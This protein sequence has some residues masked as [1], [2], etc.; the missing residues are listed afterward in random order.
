MKNVTDRYI[1]VERKL[2]HI[3]ISSIHNPERNNGRTYHVHSVSFLVI[4][5]IEA[6]ATAIFLLQAATRNCESSDYMNT[7]TGSK[8]SVDGQF[9]SSDYSFVVL[10]GTCW[11]ME[12]LVIYSGTRNTLQKNIT[13]VSFERAPWEAAYCSQQMRKSIVRSL[14]MWDMLPNH[15]GPSKLRCHGNYEQYLW[16]GKKILEKL[17]WWSKLWGLL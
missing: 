14:C 16:K 8:R 7:Y 11:S 3:R 1:S 10:P 6:P 5:V 2:T 15:S 4:N 13:R 9:T 12:P 17:H